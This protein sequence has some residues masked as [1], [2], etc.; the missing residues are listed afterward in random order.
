MSDPVTAPAAAAPEPEAAPVAGAP[1][2]LAPVVEAAPAPVI[3][4]AATPEPAPVEAPKPDGAQEIKPHTDTE[5]L[6]ESVGKTEEA[7]KPEDKPGE[8]KPDVEK[9]ADIKPAEPVAA[10]YEFKFPEGVKAEPEALN[11]YT[12]VLKTNNIAPDVGQALLDRHVAEMTRY[13]EGLNRQQHETFANTRAGWRDQVKAD[14]QIGG[15]GY[16]TSMKAVARMRDMFVSR[17]AT[18]TDG[19]KADMA[20]F[21]NFLRTTGAGDHPMFLRM[22]HN[23]AR[24]FD[25]PAPV[26]PNV[27]PPADAGKAPGSRRGSLYTHPSSQKRAG[28]S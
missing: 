6:L 13:A 10:V 4:P 1:A 3:E 17:H 8:V 22:M 25:E 14:E 19:Y 21:T 11:A 24:K 28:E 9:P 18:G 26:V 15:S 2:A 20:E 23:V 16:E 7:P 5:T 27:R 12:E